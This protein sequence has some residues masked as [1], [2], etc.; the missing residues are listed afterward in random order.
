MRRTTI[1]IDGHDY[2]VAQNQDIESIKQAAIEAVRDGGDFVTLTLV[3]N[4][5]LQ[6]L[7]S[8]GVAITVQTDEVPDDDRDDGNLAVPFEYPEYEHWLA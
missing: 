7:V 2:R 1:H 4:R 3:G 5:E 6:V 8:T